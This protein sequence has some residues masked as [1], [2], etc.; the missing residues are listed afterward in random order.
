MSLTGSASSRGLG[1]PSGLIPFVDRLAQRIARASAAIGNTVEIDPLATLAERA[2]WA[3]LSRQGTLSCGGASRL[4]QARHG[5]VAVTLAR[6]DDFELIPAWTHSEANLDPWEAVA[7][8]CA[9]HDGAT[10]VERGAMLGLAVGQIPPADLGGGPPAP[11][12]APVGTQASATAGAKPR[13]RPRT[14]LL[15]RRPMR[16]SDAVV[17]DLSSL[18]AGPLC[19]ALLAQAGCTV[20]KVES[21]HRPDGARLGSAQF[22]D[23][24]NS[25]KASVALD[26]RSAEDRVLLARLIRAA[27]VVI[28]ASRP[29]ALR[30]LGLAPADFAMQGPAV[31]ASITGYG[32]HSGNRVAF[33]DDAAVAGGL[34]VYDGDQPMFCADAIADPLSGMAAAAE[35]LEALQQGTRGH[36]DISMS[37]TARAGVGPT[38]KMPAQLVAASPTRPCQSV[39]SPLLGADTRRV[40]AEI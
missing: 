22:F 4:L 2:A 20:I 18:W 27:D 28:E 6:P 11:A 25:A 15:A 39:E 17:I 8:Y 40:L 1:P 37:E 35:I 9:L 3:E 7:R 19:G 33:G 30:Q 36:I 5:W 23:R 32:Y 34:A 29:R 16:A 13:T 21:T 26:F 14:R 12:P 38:L 31:W 24:L 10:I